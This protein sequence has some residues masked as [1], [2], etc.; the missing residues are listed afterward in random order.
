MFEDRRFVRICTGVAIAVLVAVLLPGFV[1]VTRMPQHRAEAEEWPEELGPLT[2]VRA[3]FPAQ[4]IT[5]P[6]AQEL[7][8][9][10]APLGIDF[11]KPASRL[12]IEKALQED[13][14]AHLHDVDGVGVPSQTVVDRYLLDHSRDL[15]RFCTPLLASQPIAFPQDVSLGARAP[16]PNLAAALT[17][18]R[19]LT[20][21]GLH[22]WDPPDAENFFRA[23]WRL[24]RALLGRGEIESQIAG[25]E[26]ALLTMAAVRKSGYGMKIDDLDTFDF[27]RHLLEA[28]QAEAWTATRRMAG[29][30]AASTIR[31][32]R[33]LLG[34][35]AAE[36][37]GPIDAGRIRREEMAIVA[38]WQHVD[39][40]QAEQ[41]LLPRVVQSWAPPPP[42]PP[43][44]PG[45]T[46]CLGRPVTIR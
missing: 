45:F 36:T 24:E 8:R 14:S 40:V 21:R 10:A 27:R 9:L 34:R 38:A 26:G 46:S 4:P 37:R 41:K 28:T 39:R 31:H 2:Q 35:L 33:W 12:P 20:V 17:L 15:M 7:I 18:I 3:R 42:P 25:L 23:A 19:L 11:T 1:A 44:Y 29:M 6:A 32:R 16:R 43:P 13:L 30:R 5:S 22:A